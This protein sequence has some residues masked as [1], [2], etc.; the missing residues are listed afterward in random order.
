M[1]EINQEIRLEKLDNGVVLRSKFYK[2]MSGGGGS[3]RSYA[4][5]PEAAYEVIDAEAAK[6][7]LMVLE[8]FT[9][10]SGNTDD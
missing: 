2:P 6:L 4:A 3:R 9:T 5:S 1:S 10:S 7:K 8:M